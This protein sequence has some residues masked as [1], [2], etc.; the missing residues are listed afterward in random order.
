MTVCPRHNRSAKALRGFRGHRRLSKSCAIEPATLTWLCQA[1]Q[2]DNDPKVQTAT[3]GADNRMRTRPATRSCAF[4]PSRRA[5]QIWPPFHNSSNTS[6]L[7]LNLPSTSQN[8][9]RPAEAEPPSL[10]PLSKSR[11]IEAAILSGSAT[12]N[13]PTTIARYKQVQKATDK[14]MRI[15]LG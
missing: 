2:P 10:F 4:E 15:K 11:A 14:K 13:R 12:R 5:P 1:E 3:E 7:L 6:S 8:C 9:C